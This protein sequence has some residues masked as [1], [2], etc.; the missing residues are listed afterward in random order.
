VFSI[1]P[2]RPFLDDL[3]TTLL[4]ELADPKDPFALADATVLVPN[5]RAA[6]ELAAAFVRAAGEDPP[7]TLLPSIRALGDVEEDE[8]PFEPGEIALV[9]APAISTAQRRFELAALVHAMAHALDEH[10]DPSAALPLAEELGRLLDEI[11]AASDPDLGKLREEMSP[12]L[13]EHL[14]R[15]GLFLEIVLQ[16]WPDRLQELDRIDASRRRELIMDALAKRW[17]T[18]PTDQV[19]IAAGSTGSQMATR[20]VLEA[21]ARLP[22]G[23]VVLPGLDADLDDHAWSKVDDG[24]PQRNLKRTLEKLGVSRDEV[25]AWPGSEESVGARARR[26]LVN[27]ALRPAEATDDWLARVD[28][29]K[30]E[31]KIDVAGAGIDGLSLI[32]APTPDAEARAVALAAREALEEAGRS[33]LVVTPDLS[34]ADRIDSALKRFGVQAD[35]SA[36]RPLIETAPGAFLAHILELALDPGGPV[37]LAALAKH[38]LT[39]LGRAHR[40]ARIGFAE[41]ERLALRGVRAGND[42]AAVA[43]RLAAKKETTDEAKALVADLDEAAAP[44]FALADHEPHSLA[45]FARAHV[46]AA[47]AIARDAQASGASRLWREESGEAAAVLMR[48][49]IEETE[50]FPA[51]TLDAYARIYE[52]LARARAVR[53]RGEETPRVRIL[54]PL[55]AR[56]QSADLVIAAGLNE[57]TWPARPSEDPFLSRG[58]RQAAKLPSPEKRLSLAAHDFAQLACAPRVLMTRSSRDE[59]GPTVAARWL[60]RLETLARGVLGEEEARARLAPPRDYVTLAKALDHVA[61]EEARPVGPPEARPPAAARPRRLSASRVDEWVRDP[62]GLYARRVLG[63]KPLDPLDKP[64]GAL[65]RGNAVHAALETLVRAYPE[66]L[67]KDFARRLAE[68]AIAQLEAH[69]F[70]QAEMASQVPRVRRAAVWFAD[71]ERGRREAGWRPRL[72]EAKGEAEIASPVAPFVIEAKADRI[73]IGPAGVSIL[74]YKTGRMATDDQ[75]RRWFA[76]QLGVEAVIAMLGGFEGLP[77]TPPAELAYLRVSGGR[78]PGEERILFQRAQ[79]FSVA[80][81]A[82]ETLDGLRR[83]IAEYDNPLTPYRSRTR[84]EKVSEERDFDRLAR[85]KEWASPAEDDV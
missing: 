8:P 60:W 53:R 43:R 76:P 5:R 40:S 11:A 7:A 38:E 46:E 81:Y 35:L 75:A 51:I 29:L 64:P 31:K 27:E 4:H 79:G 18:S 20:K 62:Y 10:A 24:H 55:E 19:V 48:E 34:L 65:E 82:T 59:S 58:M 85:V 17:I 25:M 13:P 26:R 56:L 69:G 16:H 67:P 61:P 30:R 39:A 22:R 70:T 71:W 44:L 78:T 54:G 28:E 74:D 42:L 9:A 84:I 50:S 33:V 68:A 37:P 66:D 14:R 1:A 73:D 6:R 21:V 32:V 36:G 47:E 77:A 80:Q 12:H 52:R 49:L 63:L 83:R 72:I 15:S 57:G 3:A 2:H 23:A 45:D 41:V